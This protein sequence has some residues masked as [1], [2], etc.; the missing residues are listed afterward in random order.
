MSNAAPEQGPPPPGRAEK[1][2]AAK[3]HAK[4]YRKGRRGERRTRRSGGKPA[5]GGK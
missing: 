5:R 4:E 2:H 3:A 1:K